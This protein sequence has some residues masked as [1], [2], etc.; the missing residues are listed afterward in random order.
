ML[1]S[2]FVAEGLIRLHF[3]GELPGRIGN[4]RQLQTVRLEEMPGEVEKV[5]FAIDAELRREYR[6]AILF[7]IAGETLS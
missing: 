6:S 3:P 5:V 1:Q 7:P 2:Q 4:E